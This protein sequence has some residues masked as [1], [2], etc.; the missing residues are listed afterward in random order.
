MVSTPD[1]ILSV[2]NSI[3]EITTREEFNQMLAE[4]DIKEDVVGKTWVKPLG[5]LDGYYVYRINYT[6]PWKGGYCFAQVEIDIELLDLFDDNPKKQDEFIVSEC[7]PY[8]EALLQ[9]YR[10]QEVTWKKK[11]SK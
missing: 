7:K 2:I 11:L 3:F 5:G 10:K 4:N 6:K 1:K 9:K 8:I